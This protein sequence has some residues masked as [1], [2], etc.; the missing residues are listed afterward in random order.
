MN[1]RIKMIRKNLN[2]TQDEFSAKIGLSRNFIAQIESGTKFP[3]DRTI[4]DICRKFSVN[5]EWL[6][7]GKGEPQRKRTRSQEIIEFTNDALED[8]D[9]SFRK[10][11]LHALAKLNITEWEVLEKIITDIHEQD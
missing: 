10:R 1:E 7:T 5:E 3:S 4:K 6:R 2:M 11:L 8:V 9:D